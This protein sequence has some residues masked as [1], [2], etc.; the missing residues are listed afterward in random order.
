MN[1]FHN[2]LTTRSGKPHLSN[3]QREHFESQRDECIKAVGFYNQGVMK[4]FFGLLGDDFNKWR[5]YD[6]ENPQIHPVHM[7][8]LM[9][10][11][12]LDKMIDYQGHISALRQMDKIDQET[13]DIET[14]KIR[15]QK[16]L[17]ISEWDL[18]AKREL[19][20]LKSNIKSI[21]D[22]AVSGEE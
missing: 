8:K 21:E 3:E 10:C 4:T 2:P 6:L 5:I 7:N 20:E 11:D 19:K 14:S 15:Y 16:L 12:H 22:N 17:A 1:D 13:Y 18:K 9:A